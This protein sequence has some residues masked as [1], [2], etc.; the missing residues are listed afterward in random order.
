MTLG[1]CSY[2]PH[3][4]PTRY[5]I[6]LAATDHVR[7]KDRVVMNY[8]L[9]DISQHV[10]KAVKEKNP[11]SFKK[12]FGVGK[13]GA[14]EIRV[15]VGDLL[16][17]SIYESGPGGLFQGGDAATRGAGSGTVLPL[18]FVASNGYITVPYAGQIKAAGRSVEQIQHSVE[19]ALKQRAIEPQ[20]VIAL[21]EQSSAEVS[22]FGTAVRNLRSRLRP[23]GERVL[24]LLARVGLVV[25]PHEALVT[26][27]RGKKRASINFQSLVENPDENIFLYPGD[28]VYVSRHQL[29]YSALGAVA[30]SVTSGVAGDVAVT[31]TSGQFVFDTPEVYLTDA[32]SR[33]GGL[34]E[35]RANT[36][37][38][39]L[40]RLEHRDLLEEIGVDLTQFSSDTDMIPTIYRA[41]FSDPSVFFAANQF[42][43]R[44]RDLIY[45]VNA[46]AVELEKFVGHVS[47]VSRGIA[48][49]VTDY[50]TLKNPGGT[51]QIN[52]TAR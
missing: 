40:Y 50:Q 28:L 32:V 16:Q 12:S 41:D 42:A 17:V 15:G 4:G 48:G 14:P 20:V 13:G 52:V 1:G 21:P 33:A 25:P 2:L 27:H 51:S 36:R 47:N 22:I 45:V 5:A 31:A 26:L 9:V 24:E 3:S 34:L 39:Y 29:K 23:G 44:N 35:G 7:K 43:M 37:G 10:L 30:N 46:D 18:Q 6:D 8:A 11:H 19:A 49:T 38:V